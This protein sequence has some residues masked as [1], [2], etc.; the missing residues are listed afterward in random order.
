MDK[1]DVEWNITQPLKIIMPSAATL[2][3]LVVIILR[4]RKTN[5]MIF[6]FHVESKI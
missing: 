2:M 6:I 1:G 5:N 4:K 3:D